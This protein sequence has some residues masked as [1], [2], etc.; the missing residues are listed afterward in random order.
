MAHQLHTDL[1][2]MESLPAMTASTAPVVLREL[3]SP[4]LPAVAGIWAAAVTSFAYA[5]VARSMSGRLRREPGTNVVREL[6]E[7]TMTGVFGTPE[8]LVRL[9]QS[10]KVKRRFGFGG[11]PDVSTFQQDDPLHSTAVYT[12][13]VHSLLRV[14]EMLYRRLS[15]HERQDYCR[16]ATHGIRAALAPKGQV[17]QSYDE[18]NFHY[19]L[20]T[21]R[22]LKFDDQFDKLYAMSSTMQLGG[23]RLQDLTCFVARILP[24][25]LLGA[26]DLAE[27]GST[28]SP[29]L[30]PS[31]LHA[32]PMV[33]Q[34]FE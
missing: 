6:F 19:R 28:P 2:L 1:P 18:L 14:Q 5:P 15:D 13:V 32:H 29:A 10:P 23:M 3:N 22:Q 27:L 24:A 8:D 7:R 26:L 33:R 31:D 11:R 16:Q 17:P 20:I 25:D 34:L 21:E 9:E 4:Q 12:I 30:V